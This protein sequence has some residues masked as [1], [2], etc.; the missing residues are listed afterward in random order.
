MA[1]L[2]DWY[3]LHPPP[4]RSVLLNTHAH[5]RINTHTRIHNCRTLLGAEA[6]NGNLF[7]SFYVEGTLINSK[8][9]P[10]IMSKLFSCVSNQMLGRTLIVIRVQLTK[11]LKKCSDTFDAG[12]FF[13]RIIW[14]LRVRP[15]ASLRVT[16]VIVTDKFRLEGQLKAVTFRVIALLPDP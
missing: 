3:D 14:L 1:W 4:P 5:I 13:C 6:L 7:K 2:G 15:F 8:A 16:L 10:K 9:W 11:K 12:L